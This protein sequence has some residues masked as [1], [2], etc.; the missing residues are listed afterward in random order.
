MPF[1][2][3]VIND[4]LGHAPSEVS[5]DAST[6]FRKIVPEDVGRVNAEIEL[7]RRTFSRFHSEFRYLHPQ[8]GEIWLEANSNPVQEPD[9][10]TIWHGFLQDITVRKRAEA[11]VGWLTGETYHRSYN[12]MTVVQGVAFHTAREEEPSQF[13]EVFCK[14]IDGLAASHDLL[15]DRGVDGVTVRDLA[16]SQLAHFANLIGTR[17][18][19]SGPAVKLNPSAAQ[20]IGMMLH[21]LATNAYKHGSLSGD[22]GTVRIEWSCGEVFRLH[23]SETGGPPAQTPARQ[24]FG[25]RVLVRMAPHELGARVRLDYADPGL[26]WHLEAPPSRIREISPEHDTRKPVKLPAFGPNSGPP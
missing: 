4:L 22:S 3:N 21:E 16:H 18:L 1:A 23:W 5:E 26:V 2:S 24:G 14:R 17:I 12:L 6:L 13:V 7:S 9:G 8:Q 15:V 20:A 25:Y 19:L 10:S 11:R